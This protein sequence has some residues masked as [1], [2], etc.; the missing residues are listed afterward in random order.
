MPSN[1]NSK[2][3]GYGTSDTTVLPPELSVLVIEE[4]SFLNYCENVVTVK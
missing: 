2:Q 3:T 4:L 1:K